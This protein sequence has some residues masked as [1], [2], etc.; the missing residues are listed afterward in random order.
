MRPYRG[1]GVRDRDRQ[2][3][4]IVGKIGPITQRV[5]IRELALRLRT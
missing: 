5:L 1:A 4:Y 3:V 2:A